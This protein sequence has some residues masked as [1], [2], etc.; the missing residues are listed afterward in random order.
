MDRTCRSDI[1]HG[2]RAKFQDFLQFVK[3]RARLVNNEFAE[4]ICAN[5]TKIKEKGKG[6]K[7]AGHYVPRSTLTANVQEE[8]DL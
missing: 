5:T 2:S 1:E 8:Q 7:V 4:D 6:Y 3:G